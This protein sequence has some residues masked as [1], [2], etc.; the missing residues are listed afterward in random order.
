MKFCT[1]YLLFLL[2]LATIGC[3]EPEN[4]LQVDPEQYAW[5]FRMA[6]DSVWRP[7][8]VPG[9]VHTDLL[10]NGLIDDPFFGT[11]EEK[12][13]W[14]DKHD[15]I[16]RTYIE[17]AP[18]LLK[19]R[20][21]DLIVKDIDTYST[22]LLN[23]S[24]ILHTDNM[25]RTYR[26]D[27]KGLLHQGKNRLE[28]R[29]ES[30][31]K[32]GLALRNSHTCWYPGAEN[33]QSE[34]GGLGDQ[35]VAPFLR[36]AQ[37]H[38]G[39]DWGP[40][41]VTSGIG[42]PVELCGWDNV[43]FDDVRFRLE[44][45]TPERA[46]AAFDITIEIIKPGIYQL[47]G[48]I[49]S[50]SLP[51]Q[52][53][54]L[55]EGD[56]I[57]RVNAGIA[58]PR[59]WW[60]NGEGEQYLY[61]ARFTLTD[62]ENRQI[63]DSLRFGIRTVA[64]EQKPDSA[65]SSF[66]FIING[67]PLF[68]KGANYIPQDVFL[69]RVTPG[70]Y[71]QLLLSA[72]EAGMNMLRVWGGGVYERDLF[73]DLCDELGLM[74][75]QDFMF[76]CAMYPGDKAFL[77]NVSREVSQQVIRLRNHPSIVLWCGN[78]EILTAWDHWGWQEQLRE[79]APAACTDTV[80]NAYDTLFHRMIPDILN[81][82]DPGR[83]YW[84]SSPQSAQGLPDSFVSGDYHYWG[85]W[86][87]GEPFENYYERVGRFMSEYG[88]QSFP[89]YSSIREFTRPE[90]RYFDS[91]VMTAHQRSSIG[92][93]TI[94][95]Y[96]ERYFGIPDNF[97][98]LVYLSQ[99]LQAK[100][101]QMAVEAHRSRMPW[102]MG[103]LLWQL[104]DCWPVASW[105]IIDYYGRRKAAWYAVRKANLP[106]ILALERRDS[107]LVVT[108]VNDTPD[109]IR[110]NLILETRTFDGTLLSN[111]SLP[112]TLPPH[113]ASAVGKYNIANLNPT[114]T[115]N[116][117]LFAQLRQDES[118]ISEN[119]ILFLNEKDVDF[120]EPR[121]TGR[122]MVSNDNWI[123]LHLRSD[124]FVRGVMLQDRA[125]EFNPGDNFFDLL[126]GKEVSVELGQNDSLSVGEIIKRLSVRTFN[127]PASVR[128]TNNQ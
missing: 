116:A 109:S 72:K 8:S 86:W 125:S 37:Y 68:M 80:W 40:R 99:L 58:H 101:M 22:I 44:N 81:R 55:A 63:S 15:W 113:S 4:Q 97:E 7:A 85:V 34:R 67:K 110:A 89:A 49:D 36:K 82:L 18:E 98:H 53:L 91:E 6:G 107:L 64:L 27:V 83:P 57:V 74:V 127:G 92:N 105:S 42:A 2:L 94:T 87:G 123:F 75:W 76:A 73:Y 119:H 9:T 43:W 26:T 112:V 66:A 38:F 100:G 95:R 16:Y 118:V 84:S 59:L 108:A 96:L 24:V 93:A 120:P 47:H 30:P 62:T 126:P 65:G 106:V 102:C 23:D 11:N 50:I 78:N 77:N 103:S 114:E 79:R 124:N 104:N 46:D 122:V 54:E 56:T 5:M 45:L 20:R 28:I 1:T 117:F 111:L 17:P 29:L 128:F 121:I 60:P 48:V 71:R 90:D 70:Q 13:Q 69:P 39:W 61:N 10:N 115:A 3:K 52:S 21:I 33:D 25:F 88:F 14:I 32:R 19:K 31:V 51:A 35:R 12:L 41:L